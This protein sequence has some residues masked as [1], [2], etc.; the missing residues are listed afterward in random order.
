VRVLTSAGDPVEAV[1]LA[2][3][4]TVLHGK[5]PWPS[6]DLELAARFADRQALPVP[7]RRGHYALDLVPGCYRIRA[8]PPPGSASAIGYFEYP[9][10]ERPQDSPCPEGSF[11]FA[12][13]VGE[14]LPIHLPDRLT[15][16]GAVRSRVGEPVAG[17]RVTAVPLEADGR[18]VTTHS[19]KDG[20]FLL[21]TDDAR[22]DLLVQPAA[23]TGLPWARVP[24]D[25]QSTLDVILADPLWIAGSVVDPAGRPV[26]R[27]VVQA[28]ARPLPEE[29]RPIGE[30]VTDEDGRFTVL[31][32]ACVACQ[33]L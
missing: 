18:E 8:V 17:A 10:G 13:S 21:R 5:R 16:A 22:Y 19:A 29:P 1:Q 25:E 4:G 9:A 24:V 27:T 23:G 28:Y 15:L 14:P 33:G 7:R 2:A 30:S 3:E 11:H 12:G 20:T 26:P 31:V 32:P 6:G